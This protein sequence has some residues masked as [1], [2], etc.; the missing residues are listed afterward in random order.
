MNLRSQGFLFVLLTSSGAGLWSQTFPTEQERL[1]WAGDLVS[2][3]TAT[4]TLSID[5][6]RADQRREVPLGPKLL[7]P[8]KMDL[9]DGAVWV[10]QAERTADQKDLLRLYRSEDGIKRDLHA[11]V[12]LK[13]AEGQVYGLYPLPQERYL[14]VARDLFRKEKE[15]SFLAVGR[16]DDN[17]KV[18]LERLLPVDLG[19]RAL[20]GAESDRFEKDILR[21]LYLGGF[22]TNRVRGT[23]SLLFA[24]GASGRLVLLDLNTLSTRL[25][26][27]FPGI[28]DKAFWSAESNRFE[29][30]LLGI[31]PRKNGHFI[32]AARSEQAVKE[33]RAFEWESG[34]NRIKAP[35]GATPEQ[36][37]A[38]IK[39]ERENPTRNEFKKAIEND[40]HI[41]FPE[42]IWWDLDPTTGTLTKLETPQG[43][44][45]QIVT[46]GELRAF[47]FRVTARDEVKVGD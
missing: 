40:G 27:V 7:S 35:T 6:L 30:G 14:L 4:G 20:E 16:R 3:I 29:Y 26:R 25:V 32:I 39:A 47:R 18:T 2:R 19:E 41:R 28:P 8:F 22:I 23:E 13:L 21:S 5:A 9:A 1:A 43:A 42:V 37:K 44:P 31:Q 33:A 24:N 36:V 38:L 46:A 11:W 15:V 34:A 12:P 45:G 10:C 17:Q